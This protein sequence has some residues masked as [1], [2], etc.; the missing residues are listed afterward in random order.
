MGTR[1]GFTLIELLVVIAII[2]I[3][4][5]ILFPVFASAREKARETMCASN[6]KQMAL[7]MIQYVQDYDEMY[8]GFTGWGAGGNYL[9]AIQPYTKSTGVYLCPSNPAGGP[10]GYA[11]TYEMNGF[12]GCGTSYNWASSYPYANPTH[13]VVQWGGTPCSGPAGL[14]TTPPGLTLGQIAFP[15]VTWLYWESGDVYQPSSGTFAVYNSSSSYTAGV[16]PTSTGGPFSIC[17]FGDNNAYWQK[18]HGGFNIAYTD[19]HVK[20]HTSAY[21]KSLG[22]TTQFACAENSTFNGSLCHSNQV[23]DQEPFQ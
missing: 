15:T 18:Y 20:F 9:A 5:A 6:E 21:L 10:G 8:P 19:G 12:L 3:L 23:D 14:W 13:G 16:C 22:T 17:W 7:A 2:A 4:A 1:K 11:T